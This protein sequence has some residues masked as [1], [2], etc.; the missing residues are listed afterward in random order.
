MKKI[1]LIFVTSLLRL[2]TVINNNE[3]GYCHNSK[4]CKGLFF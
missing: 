3:K 4:K 1:G 2:F